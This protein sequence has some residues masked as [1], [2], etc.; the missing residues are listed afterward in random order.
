MQLMEDVNNI[1]GIYDNAVQEEINERIG[2]TE[3]NLF[4]GGVEISW[5]F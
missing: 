1:I 2:K 5:Y 4:E 3:E